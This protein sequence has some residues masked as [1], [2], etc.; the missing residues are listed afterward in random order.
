MRIILDCD[1]GNGVPGS[2]VDDGLALGLILRSPEFELEAVSIVGGN[3]ALEVGTLAGLAVLEAAGAA[4]PLYQ[5]A[6]RPLVEDHAPWRA[7]LDGRRGVEPAV[8][9][10]QGT[11]YPAP[12]GRPA[13]GSGAEAIVRI[14]N[15]HPGE[16]TIAA[17]GPLTNVA[18]AILIDPELPR[19][20][21]QI[22]IM[23]GAFNMWHR[24]QELNVCYDPEAARIVV[25]CGAPVVMVPLDTTMRTAML[26]EDIARLVASTDKLAHLLGVTCEPWLRWVGA[27]RNRT[28]F[29]LH[30]PLA[31]AVL[32]ERRFVSVERAHVDI[33]LLGRLTRGRPVSW[34]PDDPLPTCG[35][36]L[37]EVPQIEIVTDVDND[38]FKAFLMQ[39]L[40]RV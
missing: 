16:V 36:R 18:E 4:V 14:V 9:L 40:L 37:P 17:V 20:V 11:P 7:H 30:D 19:K 34:L 39:R 3:T 38:A 12:K 29:A 26:A 8:S 10:Y 2:D 15:A 23:G 6:P 5:G 1:P 22:A 33:E 25:T 13:P 21:R 35:L 32:L 31:V 27:V 24:P 28:G